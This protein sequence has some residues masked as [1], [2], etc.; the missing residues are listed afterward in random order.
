MNRS[1]YL[2][3]SCIAI[4]FLGL[5]AFAETIQER[6]KGKDE[7]NYEVFLNGIP[8]GTTQW[9]YVGKKQLENKEADVLAVISDTKILQFLN[10]VGKENVFLDSKTHLPLRVERDLVVFGKKEF[11]EEIYNQEEGYVKIVKTTGKKIKEEILH[12]DRPIYNILTLLYFFPQDIDLKK[13]EVFFFSLPTQRVE[14]KVFAP[15]QLSTKKGKKDTFFLVGKGAKRFNLW[16][17]KENR[18][19]L[20]LEFIFAAGKIIIVRKD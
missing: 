10:L 15:R 11:I 13:G 2:T 16:L 18:L 14:I 5:S 8:C 1:A 9:Q 19:P 4:C 7:L 20:R 17:D 12:R 3:I 6:F